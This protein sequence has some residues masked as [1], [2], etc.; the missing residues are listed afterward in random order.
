VRWYSHELVGRAVSADFGRMPLSDGEP[1]QTQKWQI[2]PVLSN[3]NE[4]KV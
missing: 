3:K 4:F 2:K 1:I